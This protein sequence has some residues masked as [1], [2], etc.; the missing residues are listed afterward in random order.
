[1]KRKPKSTDPYYLRKKIRVNYLLI[2]IPASADLMTSTL[3][4]IAL[5]YISPSIYQML[6]G[7]VIIVTAIF[8]MLFLKK[9]PT[10]AEIFG[11]CLAVFG[12]MIVGLSAVLFSSS[13]ASDV[14]V[15]HLH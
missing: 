12:I 3:Q 2:A 5:N 10:R 13:K 9:K 7:G 8:S 6:R 4:Y 14:S 1:L 15:I 11:C